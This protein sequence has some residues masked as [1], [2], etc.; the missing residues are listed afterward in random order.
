MRKCAENVQNLPALH[1]ITFRS[2]PFIIDDAN[3]LQSFSL[4][5]SKDFAREALEQANNS[6][7]DEW[8]GD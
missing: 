2:R 1:A 5:G 4:S 7:V 3:R 6:R 8:H